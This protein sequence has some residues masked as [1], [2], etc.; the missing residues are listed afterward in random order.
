MNWVLTL[1]GLQGPRFQQKPEGPPKGWMSTSFDNVGSEIPGWRFAPV[2]SLGRIPLC[3]LTPEYNS[4]SEGAKST[5]C[6]LH[7]DAVDM[8]ETKPVE[9]AH[10]NINQSVGYPLSSHS[11]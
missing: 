1:G 4:T 3:G 5:R 7:C 8:I 2:R 9:Y 10:Q 11:R 6:L